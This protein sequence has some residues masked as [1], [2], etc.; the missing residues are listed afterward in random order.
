MGK[1]SARLEASLLVR[2]MLLSESLTARLLRTTKNLSAG[3]KE[4]SAGSKKLSA[5]SKKLLAGTTRIWR[6][7]NIYTQDIVYCPNKSESN[8]K[9]SGALGSKLPLDQCTFHSWQPAAPQILWDIFECLLWKQVSNYCSVTVHV[10]DSWL[11]AAGFRL[12][13]HVV[14]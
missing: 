14:I 9:G 10:P 8:L 3:S 2:R 6:G 1:L 5:G 11:P 7:C 4:L 13:N 12:P